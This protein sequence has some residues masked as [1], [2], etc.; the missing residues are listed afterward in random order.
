LFHVSGA[1][2]SNLRAPN[3]HRAGFRAKRGR[4]PLVEETRRD[5][6]A[7]PVVQAIADEAMHSRGGGDQRDRVVAEGLVAG[8]LATWQSSRRL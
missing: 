1:A 6:E 3:G 4:A 8:T 5:A 2:G 7:G